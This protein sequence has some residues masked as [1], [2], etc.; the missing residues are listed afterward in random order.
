MHWALSL[1]FLQHGEGA[2]EPFFF[3]MSVSAM[4]I[5][6]KLNEDEFRI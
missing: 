4:R 2:R 3:L 6:F 1:E 5:G